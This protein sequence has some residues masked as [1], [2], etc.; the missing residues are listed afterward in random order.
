MGSRLSWVRVES[1]RAGFCNEGSG[2]NVASLDLKTADVAA[3]NRF[4]EEFYLRLHRHMV[5]SSTVNGIVLSL[6]APLAF[7]LYVKRAADD[8]YALELGARMSTLMVRI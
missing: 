4:V 5:A 8:S 7:R 2:V 6:W 3:I 1:A